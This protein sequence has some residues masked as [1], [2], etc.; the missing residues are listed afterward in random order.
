MTKKVLVLGIMVAALATTA[1]AALWTEDFSAAT[2]YMDGVN[3]WPDGDLYNNVTDRGTTFWSRGT[4][5]SVVNGSGQLEMTA[6][7]DIQCSMGN[8][9]SMG[10][11]RLI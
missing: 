10:N 11:P 5:E 9:S 7:S 3:P 1:Q 2:W 8:P 4:T 6:H